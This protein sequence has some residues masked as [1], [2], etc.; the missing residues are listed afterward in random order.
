MGNLWKKTK[1]PMRWETYG[2][3]RWETYKKLPCYQIAFSA[4]KRWET[5]EKPIAIHC[6]LLKAMA[7]QPAGGTY[8]PRSVGGAIMKRP[9][10]RP[11][12]FLN[13]VILLYL[14]AVPCVDGSWYTKGCFGKG[15]WWETYR[16]LRDRNA[17]LFLIFGCL[18]NSVYI[19]FCIIHIS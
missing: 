1:R 11:T 10:I 8:D 4:K 5:F 9:S 13:N 6:S 3:M 12:R 14:F 17:Q 2:K 15:N 19:P 18:S 16:K 7:F